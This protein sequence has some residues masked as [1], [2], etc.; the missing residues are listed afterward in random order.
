MMLLVATSGGN[1]VACVLYNTREGWNDNSTNQ[2]LPQT[3]QLTLLIGNFGL[4]DVWCVVM[5][6]RLAE[7]VYY[8]MRIIMSSSSNE[9]PWRVMRPPL[10]ALTL[11]IVIIP[12]LASLM[13][14]IFS[15]KLIN[16]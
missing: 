1:L 5:L 16:C 2:T 12:I 15:S 11:F 3:H 7:T 10:D 14:S 8:T 6:S 4:K 9:A 13:S